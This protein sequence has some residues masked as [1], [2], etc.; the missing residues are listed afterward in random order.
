LQIEAYL[1]EIHEQLLINALERQREKITSQNH[2]ITERTLQAEWENIKNGL[3]AAES[4]DRKSDQN[5]PKITF[6]KKASAL[7]AAMVNTSHS[8]P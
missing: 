7:S 3:S 8:L 5:H 2:D 4:K 1:A 6:A